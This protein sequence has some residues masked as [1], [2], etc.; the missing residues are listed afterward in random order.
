VTESFDCALRDL[1]DDGIF[2]STVHILFSV[3]AVCISWLIEETAHSNIFM[4]W[5]HGLA[6]LGGSVD[7]VFSNVLLMFTLN[8]H[9][10]STADVLTEQ[11]FCM[12]EVPW[13]WSSVL[14]ITTYQIILLC[15]MLDF[16]LYINFYFVLEGT[17]KRTL[18]STTKLM[19]V[20]TRIYSLVLCKI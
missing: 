2:I 6:L 1:H 4:C 14:G 19:C 8:Y 7:V 3:E 10:L 9:S 12:C 11:V 17:S 15:E 20:R 5:C 13:F 16:I 18:H